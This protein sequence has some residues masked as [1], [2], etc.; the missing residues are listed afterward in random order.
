MKNIYLV[1]AGC[2]YGDTYYLPYAAGM[3]AAFAM[4]DPMLKEE[5]TIKRIIYS[6]EDIDNAISNMEKPFFVGFSNSIWNYRYNVIRAGMA[7]WQTRMVQVHV[8]AIS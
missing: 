1:Q 5:C 6:L 8:I 2:L 7:E 4:N 3:L